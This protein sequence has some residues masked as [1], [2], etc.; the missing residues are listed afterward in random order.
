MKMPANGYENLILHRRVEWLVGLSVPTHFLRARNG[1][2]EWIC[3]A[4]FS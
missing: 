4:D 1:R 3:C 2:I